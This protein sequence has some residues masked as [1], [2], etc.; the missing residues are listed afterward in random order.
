MALA[1]FRQRLTRTVDLV[2]VE[3]GPG[4]MGLVRGCGGIGIVVE[5]VHNGGQAA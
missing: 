1:I 4:F 3:A 2:L 5:H